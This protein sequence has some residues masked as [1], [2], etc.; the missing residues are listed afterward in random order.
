MTGMTQRFLSRARLGAVAVIAFVGGLLFAAGFN[1]TPFGY[2]QQ[3]K[4]A[5]LTA[6]QTGGSLA[7]TGGDFVSIA[8]RV[9]PAVVS[10]VTER[11]ATK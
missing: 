9:T 5:A 3:Q 1:L 7:G 2:A 6:S 11:N 10:I 4:T 8:E